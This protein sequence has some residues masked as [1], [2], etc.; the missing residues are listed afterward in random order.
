[1]IRI[2]DKE[3]IEKKKKNEQK[4]NIFDLSTGPYSVGIRTEYGPEKNPYLGTFH[5]AL[6]T[7]LRIDVFSHQFCLKPIKCL[8]CSHIETSHL[9]CCVNQLTGFYMRATLALNGLKLLKSMFF[10]LEEFMI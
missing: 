5:A 9:V 10:K 6:T 3:I 7:T 1:M 8:G 4:I 2:L